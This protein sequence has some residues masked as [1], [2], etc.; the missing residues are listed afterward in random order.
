MVVNRGLASPLMT[1]VRQPIISPDCDKAIRC[2]GEFSFIRVFHAFVGRL[3]NVW[4]LCF[5]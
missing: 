5:K 4:E 2:L 3:A 1:S